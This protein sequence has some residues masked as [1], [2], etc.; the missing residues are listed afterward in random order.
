MRC[1]SSGTLE[2]AAHCSSALGASEPAAGA[3]RRSCGESSS[4]KPF[5]WSVSVG[6]RK[7]LWNGRGW[8]LARNVTHA[9]AQTHLL[10]FVFLILVETI[11]VI[12]FI[13]KVLVLERF[14][15]GEVDCTRDNQGCAK[16]SRPLNKKR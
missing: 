9:L 8:R 16:E 7:G 5:T 6:G 11:I 2:E 14:A 10:I 3:R 13:F 12:I 4:S 15:G 1:R